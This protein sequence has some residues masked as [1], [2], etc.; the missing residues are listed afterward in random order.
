MPH[1]LARAVTARIADPGA[2]RAHSRITPQGVACFE[3]C[4]PDVANKIIKLADGALEPGGRW[5]ISKPGDRF[6]RK[7]DTENTVNERRREI[8]G[9]PAARGDSGLAV[10]NHDYAHQAANGR[11]LPPPPAPLLGG[12]AREMA[13]G[14]ARHT[15]CGRMSHARPEGFALRWHD[16][17][18]PAV[19]KRVLHWNL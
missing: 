10:I 19:P 11:R 18:E 6:Q 12:G 14:A 15:R 3:H 8:N 1:D 2:M 7:A 9:H 17:V 5:S 4:G 13:A 16:R